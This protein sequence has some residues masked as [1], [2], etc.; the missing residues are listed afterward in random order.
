MY[1]HV[2]VPARDKYSVCIRKQECENKWVYLKK[3]VGGFRDGGLAD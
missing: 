2:R 3:S 1:I